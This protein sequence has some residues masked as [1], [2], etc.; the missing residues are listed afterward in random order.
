MALTLSDDA[1]VARR[2]EYLEGAPFSVESLSTFLMHEGI[3]G[4]GAR[5]SAEA[6]IVHGLEGGTVIPVRVGEEVL[7]QKLEAGSDDEA[8]STVVWEIVVFLTL[9]VAAGFIAG[10]FL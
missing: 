2:K 9:A 1:K 3:F 10:K 8:P 7:Y 6:E 4:Q 5:I